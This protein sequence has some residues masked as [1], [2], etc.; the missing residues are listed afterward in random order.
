[1]PKFD[2]PPSRSPNG[3]WLKTTS[4]ATNRLDSRICPE[5]FLNLFEP[6]RNRTFARLNSE[7]GRVIAWWLSPVHSFSA[8]IRRSSPNR[9]KLGDDVETGNRHARLCLA[10][11][12]KNP[13]APSVRWPQAPKGDRGARSMTILAYQMDLA[14]SIPLISLP[15]AHWMILGANMLWVETE[16]RTVLTP[17]V[18]GKWRAP[19]REMLGAC[20][21]VPRR[22]ASA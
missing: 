15:V 11:E 7:V 13:V 5:E 17:N 22:C 12:R 2:S 10:A 18:Q 20:T 21:S 8:G 9:E 14:H 19:A 3:S 6:S 1:M 4:W 16:R